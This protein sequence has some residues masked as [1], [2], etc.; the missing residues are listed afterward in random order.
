M[1][2]YYSMGLVSCVASVA[3]GLI[4]LLGGIQ[5]YWVLVFAHLQ[6]QVKMDASILDGL[7]KHMLPE[8][9]K[10]FMVGLNKLEV[11]IFSSQMIFFSRVMIVTSK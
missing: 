3:M 8:I 10:Q 9:Y 6:D 11:L 1:P 7:I 4:W 2:G 5:C